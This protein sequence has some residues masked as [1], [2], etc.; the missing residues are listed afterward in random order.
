MAKWKMVGFAIFYVYP[1]IVKFE[2]GL[3]PKNSASV[4]LLAQVEKLV[5]TIKNCSLDDATETDTST[6][7]VHRY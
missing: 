1:I 7:N 5:S 2:K 6:V 3:I 4:F